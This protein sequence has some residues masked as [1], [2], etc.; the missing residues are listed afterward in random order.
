MQTEGAVRAQ[1][2]TGNLWGW[3][4]A[5]LNELTSLVSKGAA[6]IHISGLPHSQGQE[7]GYRRE[8]EAA[9]CNMKINHSEIQNTY[10]SNQLF[11]KMYFKGEERGSKLHARFI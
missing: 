5:P 4:L 10:V 11:F 6:S 9:E 1:G 3:L 7:K 2:G 8:R